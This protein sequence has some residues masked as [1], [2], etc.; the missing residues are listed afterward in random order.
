MAK[1]NIMK[2]KMG[3]LKD[4]MGHSVTSKQFKEI[5]RRFT[6]NA[7]AAVSPYQ[8]EMAEKEKDAEIAAKT[9]V[10]KAK[11]KAAINGFV[12]KK[13]TLKLKESMRTVKGP[14]G[15]EELFKA[16]YSM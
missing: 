8:M 6:E 5:D 7:K 11:A 3:G 9:A 15:K 12:P 4:E 14:E 1:L 2:K 16:K 13:G 10:Y